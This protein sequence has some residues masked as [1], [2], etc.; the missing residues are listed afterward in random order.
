MIRFG[1]APKNPPRLFHLES[2]TLTSSLWWGPGNRLT[3]Y[4]LGFPD[5]S[6]VSL[7]PKLQR[8]FIILYTAH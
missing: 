7:L 8:I 6:D 3:M 1:R 2:P 5:S 4:I